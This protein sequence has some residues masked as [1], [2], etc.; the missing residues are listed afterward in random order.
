M[1][2]R[3]DRQAV[4]FVAAMDLEPR[5]RPGHPLRAIKRMADDDLAK[6]SRRLGAAYAREGRP[7][8][9]PERLIKA[10]LLQALYS[11]R[12]EAELVER[13]DHGLLFRG[14]PD[15]RIDEPVFDAT[16]FSHN[17][18]RLETHGLAGAFFDHTVRRALAQGLAS[19]DPFGVDGSLI[20]AHASIKSFKPRGSADAAGN[21]PEGGAGFKRRNPEGDFHGQK[22]S[23]ATHASKTGPQA[24]LIKKGDG[25][26]ARLCHALHALGENRHGLVRA[27][28]VDSPLG[29]SEP[30]TAVSLIDRVRR[31]FRPR[32]KTVGGDE[33]FDRGPFP[34]ALA[35]RETTPH[36][37]VKEGVLG[38]ATGTAYRRRHARAI[39]ARRRMRRRTR[40]VGYGLSQRCRKKIEGWF[41]RAKTVAGLART[42]RIGHAKTSPQARVAAAAFNLIRMRKLA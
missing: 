24:K 8:V 34:E 5:V 12:S 4:L 17:R 15:M 38:A 22:R 2:G 19:P 7:G 39:A 10:L 6:M 14:F 33:G 13:I 32:P 3:A 35:E 40:G 27:V 1:R 37:A 26:P 30:T 25:Q 9:P 21:D 36:V 41:G 31:R 11:I 20:E 29:N 16:V 18:P 23:H 28:G 42:R